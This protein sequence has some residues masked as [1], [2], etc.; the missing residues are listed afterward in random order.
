MPT[1]NDRTTRGLCLHELSPGKHRHLLRNALDTNP[2]PPDRFSPRCSSNDPLWAPH[3]H[4]S[5]LLAVACSLANSPL[6]PYST[7]PTPTHPPV[8]PKR[9]CRKEQPLFKPP[10]PAQRRRATNRMLT[11]SGRS[12]RCLGVGRPP[13]RRHR[14][15]PREAVG[16]ET[17]RSRPTH[18]P[19]SRCGNAHNLLMGFLVE[20]VYMAP[21]LLSDHASPRLHCCYSLFPNLYL[22]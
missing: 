19:R 2:P 21:L 1:L 11:A 8:D 15:C 12:R 7:P 3:R 9:H 17:T 16:R 18:T 13:A 22:T 14:M 4:R 10:H 6:P 20:L 5:I